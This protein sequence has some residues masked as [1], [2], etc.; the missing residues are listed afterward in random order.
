MQS[1]ISDFKIGGL[2]FQPL[3][4]LLIGVVDDN[5]TSSLPDASED[6]RKHTLRKF[7][8]EPHDQF[9]DLIHLASIQ[10]VFDPLLQGQF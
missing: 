7:E 9:S 10:F 6:R 8:D 5:C 2:V 4:R 1:Q 3:H